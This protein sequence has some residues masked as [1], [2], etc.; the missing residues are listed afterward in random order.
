[1]DADRKTADDQLDFIAFVTSVAGFAAS[2]D[3]IA[4]STAILAVL[5]TVYGITFYRW[6]VRS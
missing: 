1:M 2:I 3:A 4:P 6:L 5:F